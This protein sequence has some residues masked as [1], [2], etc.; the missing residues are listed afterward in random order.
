[1]TAVVSLGSNAGDRAAHLRAGVELLSR[2]FALLAL[3][4]RYV[5]A[6]VGVTGQP[7]FLNAVAVFDCAD[8]EALLAAAHRAE[9]ARGR[10][11]PYRWAARP[12]DVDLVDVDGRQRDDPRLTLPHPRA[13]QRAFV[14]APW[15]DVDAEAELVGHGPVWRLLRRIDRSG[16]RRLRPGEAA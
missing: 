8:P 16:I 3:S 4:P 12:L 10:I 11:R 2:Q 6:P 5:T 9:E 15:Y 14:L 1:M 7:D 13:Y